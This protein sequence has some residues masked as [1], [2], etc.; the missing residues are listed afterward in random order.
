MPVT[1]PIPNNPAVK[2]ARSVIMRSALSRSKVTNLNNV[3]VDPVDTV[4][5]TWK[6]LENSVLD[7]NWRRI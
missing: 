4:N 2:T 5:I 1:L 3:D 7:P 6:R